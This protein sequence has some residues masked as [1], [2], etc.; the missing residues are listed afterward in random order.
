MGPAVDPA[1]GAGVVPE[2]WLCAHPSAAANNVNAMVFIIPLFFTSRALLDRLSYFAG[3]Q[4]HPLPNGVAVTTF[5]I[6][7]TTAPLGDES[8]GVHALNPPP[9]SAPGPERAVF[10]K[11]AG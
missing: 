7:S 6:P 4:V 2:D 8:P 5:F 3:S 10:D 9:V 11:A 1:A